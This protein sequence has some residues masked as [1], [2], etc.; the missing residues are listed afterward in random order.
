MLALSREIGWTSPWD[1]LVTAD[2]AF[3]PLMHLVSAGLGELVGHGATNAAAT[4]L[5]WLLLLAVATGGMAAMLTG[6][7]RAGFAAAT[8]TFLVPAL[9]G[10]AIRYYYDLPMTALLWASAAALMLGFHY[11]RAVVG[12]LTAGLLLAAAALTKWPALAFGAPLLLAVAVT[13]LRGTSARWRPRLLG[14]MTAMLAAALPLFSFLAGRGDETSFASMTQW[15]STRR[16]PTPGART[17]RSIGLLLRSVSGLGIDTWGLELSF[18]GDHWS[19]V[20][21]LPRAPR[22]SSVDPLAPYCARPRDAWSQ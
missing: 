14:L 16:L 6:E 20:L 5:L 18:Y 15:H 2:R 1:I 19:S 10:A 22:G 8:A 12:G 7:R 3:P 4:G 17:G 9:S 13:P 21:G 11:R